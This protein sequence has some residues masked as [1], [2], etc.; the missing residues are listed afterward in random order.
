MS[1]DKYRLRCL[2]IFTL[3]L[4]I[5]FTLSSEMSGG[6]FALAQEGNIDS[7]EDESLQN[8]DEAAWQNTQEGELL[9]GSFAEAIENVSAGGI[10]ILRSDISLTTGI[11]VSKPI[12]ITSWDADSP[13]TIKNMTADTDDRKDVGRIFTVA[14]CQLI[15]QDIILDGGRNE[16][17]AAYHPLICVTNSAVLRIYNGT[18]LQNA[19]NKSESMCGGGVNIRG[20]VLYM[21]GG[22]AITNCKA[23]HGGGVEVNSKSKDDKQAMFGMAGG[24]IE[25]CTADCG[26][27]V[28]VNIG[29][30]QMVGGKI[31]GCTAVS[32]EYDE[33]GG[34]IYVASPYHDYIAAV[35]ITG[36]EISGNTAVSGGGGILVCGGHALLQ[37]EGGIVKENEATTGG[38][39]NMILGTMRLFG[40]TVTENTAELYGGGVL[41]SPDSVIFM[42]GAPKVFCNTAKDKEDIFDNLYLDGA[43]DDGYP[44]SPIRLIGSLT[45]GVNLGMSRWVLPDDGEHPYRQMIVPYGGYS[46]SQ[47]DLDRLCYDRSAENKEL[48]ADN[49]EKYAFIPYNGEIVMVLA[50][51]VTLDKESL[52]FEGVSSS[53]ETLTATVTPA[54]APENSVT[55]SSSNEA[56]A[57]VDGNGN[58]TPIGKGTTIITATTKSPYHATASCYVT[59]DCYQLT[60]KAVHGMLTYTPDEPYGFFPSGQLITLN[61][62]ADEGYRLHSL[63]AYQ[64]E[65]ES[66]E[67]VINDDNTII[68]PEHNGT[69]EAVFEP[70]PY[71]INYDLDGGALRDGETNPESY[72]I[73]SSEITLNN[74]IRSGYT[75]V[76]WTG[77]E[78]TDST[79]VVTIPTGST[80]AREYT[81]VWEENN[82]DSSDNNS[83]TSSGG[84]SKP[85]SDYT[86]S[87][88]DESK[89]TESSDP[90]DSDSEPSMAEES[91]TG[92]ESKPTD[93]RDPLDNESSVAEEPSTG[94][95]SELTSSESAPTDNDNNPSTGRAISLIPLSVIVIVVTLVAK[96][97]RENL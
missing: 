67:V 92:D 91:S 72:T 65:E 88:N 45:D 20:G 86:P 5:L 82:S 74:P 59:V 30:F 10:V 76:G 60:T 73:E 34:G 14:G 31:T 94:D 44:T 55:W 97:K 38:G 9:Y 66:V 81:A 29:Q 51:D 27:G 83:S 33:G 40:G 79:F 87:T 13:C 78:L 17:V 90:S 75:F 96:K 23:R 22:S 24:S 41:G 93:S 48:Y 85:T 54:N 4:S 3:C 18:L 95:E 52:S 8:Q 2:L 46:F 64:T 12:T 47:S 32:E 63:K 50:V 69:V 36:G 35:R 57:T 6:V 1:F 11:T 25:N 68:M 53:S 16:G 26:G 89:P 21:Y 61:V 58:V 39:I 43:D 80:G 71:P 19:E 56:V 28:Y 84:G 42:Q 7:M 77:A 49:P 37:F 62:V 70:I 15:L